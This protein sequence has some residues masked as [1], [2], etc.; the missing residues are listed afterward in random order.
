[1]V[2]APGIIE[3]ALE[4]LQNKPFLRLLV[5]DHA[6]LEELFGIAELSLDAG[7]RCDEMFEAVSCL[8]RH[9]RIYLQL[10]EEFLYPALCAAG[11]YAAAADDLADSAAILINEIDALETQLAINRAL[12]ASY[13]LTALT[14]LHAKFTQRIAHIRQSI[15]PLL[16]R[17]LST[18]LDQL[19]R[20]LRERRT[21]LEVTLYRL[22]AT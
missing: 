1:M 11:D 16:R 12:P 4:S 15:F 21:E 8:T 18:R 10:D 17:T 13:I 7:G 6:A 5:D 22:P 19:G 2:F 20:Q 9:L 3:N 14:A